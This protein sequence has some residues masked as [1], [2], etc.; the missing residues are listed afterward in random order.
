MSDDLL[1]QLREAMA[2]TRAGAT[3]RPVSVTLPEPLA[4]A[5]KLLSAAGHEQ[6]VS[7]AAT[8]ALEARLQSIMIGLQADAVY[9][10]FPDARPT[11]DDVAAMADRLGVDLP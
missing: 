2:E 7:A 9:A 1:D 10:E 5:F 4:D 11:E 8:A 3:T 6:N